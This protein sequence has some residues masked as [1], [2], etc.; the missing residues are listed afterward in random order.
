MTKKTHKNFAQVL[1]QTAPGKVVIH[2]LEK[3]ASAGTE[4]FNIELTEKLAP[5]DTLQVRAESDSGPDTSFEVSCRLDTPVEVTYWR[6]GG[7]LNTV[8]R[9]MV[10][11]A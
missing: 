10:T 1:L 8:L 11:E 4:V 9:G 6:N 2:Q 7:I 3:L 5:G